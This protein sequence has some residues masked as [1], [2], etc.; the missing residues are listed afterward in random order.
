M[1]KPVRWWERTWYL[2][3]WRRGYMQMDTGRFAFGAWQFRAGFDRCDFGTGPRGADYWKLALHTPHVEFDLVLL[4][5][6]ERLG[7]SR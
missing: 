3:L 4:T 5:R 6:H 7:I 2:N 1:P